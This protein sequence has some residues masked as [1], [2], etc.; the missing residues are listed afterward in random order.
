MKVFFNIIFLITTSVVVSQETNYWFHQTGATSSLKG[1]IETA[2]VRN[3]SA[4]F[5]NPG[6]L[7][8]IEKD[9]IEGQLDV[10]S[11][12]F[13]SMENAGGEN[14]DLSFLGTEVTPAMF[15]YLKKSKRNSKITYAFGII[16]RMTF[17]NS[18][19]LSYENKG[20][21]LLPID[22]ND[23]FQGKYEYKNK[24]TE[25]WFTGSFSYRLNEFIGIGLSTN[26]SLRI[27]DYLK[28]YDARAFPEDELDLPKQQFSNITS[29][30]ERQSLGYR[31]LAIIFKPGISINLDQLK[32]G[33]VFTTPNLNIGLLNSFSSRSQL[34]IFPDEEQSIVS[35]LNSLSFYKGAYKTPLSINIGAEYVFNKTSIAFTTEWF[36]KIEPYEMIKRKNFSEELEYP[37]ATNPQYAI[38]VMANKSI[39]NVG[40][41]VTYKIKES[42]K[43]IG[44]FRTDFNYFDEKALN[45]NTDFVPNFSYWDVYHFTS[46]VILNRKKTDLTFGFNYGFNRTKNDLQFV[47]MT[48]ANQSNSLRG[49]L[50]NNTKTQFHSF[51][52][53]LGINFNL[54][55]R[56]H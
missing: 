38:P 16:S 9:I 41:A 32:L 10:I 1:G 42:F 49:D 37:T 26:V 18:F 4:V 24:L 25:N 29:N 47:N 28:Y 22:D 34:S 3:T 8:F 14:I 48:N 52:I 17:N 36:S 6:A 55:N 54:S 51:S 15:T 12:N 21:Y 31:G 50:N 13:I 20:E 53:T 45:R 46:G 19:D 27:Q 11:I 56:N 5:Y 35:E 33:M 7:S 39:V 2:G 44:S 43:Y 40:I 23:I 30:I